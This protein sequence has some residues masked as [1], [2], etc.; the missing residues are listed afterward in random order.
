MKSGALRQIVCCSKCEAKRQEELA[1]NE[2]RGDTEIEN[3]TT[4]HS[5]RPDQPEVL[6]S[7]LRMADSETGG[8]EPGPTITFFITDGTVSASTTSQ[9]G[10]AHQRRQISPKE[11][12]TKLNRVCTHQ[13]GRDRWSWVPG[14]S[15]WSAS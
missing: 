9:A 12:R 10:P 6:A 7:M 15:T 5:G 11:H 13:A 2:R 4:A 14:S 1:N 8:D 3:S